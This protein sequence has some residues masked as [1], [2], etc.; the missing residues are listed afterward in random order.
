MRLII[1]QHKKK[2]TTLGYAYQNSSPTF[3]GAYAPSRLEAGDFFRR[4]V[5]NFSPERRL[6]IVIH[7]FIYITIIFF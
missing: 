5:K 3:T 1:S 2:E 6:K 4:Y 7:S